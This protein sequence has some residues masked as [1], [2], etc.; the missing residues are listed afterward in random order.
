MPYI[1]SW[2]VRACVCAGVCVEVIVGSC[3]VKKNNCL[4]SPLK[5]NL[6]PSSLAD[7]KSQSISQRKHLCECVWLWHTHA[8]TLKE[9]HVWVF[10]HV[11]TS[12]G[13]LYAP[14]DPKQF[15][16]HFDSSHFMISVV[17]IMV[18]SHSEDSVIL[19]H[20]NIFIYHEINWA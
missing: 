16:I 8:Y 12:K 13:N 11:F 15:F 1:K 7:G 14:H 3:H 20:D 4:W 17:Y 19:K 9:G 6:K 10:L 5:I 2:C 18:F